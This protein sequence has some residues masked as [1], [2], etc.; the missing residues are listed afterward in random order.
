MGWQEAC[1]SDLAV[2]RL[3][4]VYWPEHWEV[5][6]E[7]VDNVSA[8][9]PLPLEVSRTSRTHHSLVPPWRRSAGQLDM[10]LGGRSVRHGE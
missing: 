4:F 10:S 7:V 5:Q 6:V 2:P 9:L 8:D 1:Q 3:W